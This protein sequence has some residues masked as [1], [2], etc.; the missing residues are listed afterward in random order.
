M[1]R[2]PWHITPPEAGVAD[3]SRRA[4]LIATG[5]GGILA[6]A[7]CGRGDIQPLE[8]PTPSPPEEAPPPEPYSYP[9]VHEGLEE[10]NDPQLRLLA[11]Y[12]RRLGHG[13]E[14]MTLVTGL[15]HSAEEATSHAKAMHERLF[16]WH[17]FG[18][19]P[20]VVM[21]PRYG[22]EAADLSRLHSQDYIGVADSAPGVLD[23]Y[24]RTLRW[25]GVTDEQMGTWVPYPEPN[26]PKWGGGVTD[27]GTFRANVTGAAQCIKTH[28]SNA[29]VSIMLDSTS[30]RTGDDA[31]SHLLSYTKGI[32]HPTDPVSSNL[33]DSVGLQGLP[34]KHGDRAERFL[35]AQ[36]VIACAN[37][38]DVKEVWVA[39]GSFASRKLP[40][41]GRLTMSDAA[42]TAQLFDELQQLKLMQAAGLNVHVNLLVGNERGVDWSYERSP[43]VLEA[44]LTAAAHA[45]FETTLSF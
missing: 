39:S 30:Y 40:G 28:F 18:I 22:N 9:N 43:L 8:A 6:I 2:D 3:P 11:A 20:I 25:A 37:E 19:K 1:N 42:R 26:V 32:N 13:L 41:E 24:F 21:E 33:V 35:P 27:P 4:L 10:S 12:E 44:A 7:G 15:P 45:G 16:K 14:Y 29:K 34:A 38:L 36:A 5:A 23:I 17:K 31:K